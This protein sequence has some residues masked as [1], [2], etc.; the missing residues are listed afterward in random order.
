MFCN[1]CRKL[2][3]EGDDCPTCGKPIAA[4]LPPPTDFDK[5]GDLHEK[6]RALRNGSL[7]PGQFCLYLEEERAKV[8]QARQKLA[9]VEESHLEEAIQSWEQA[10]NYAEQW[11]QSGNDLML[12]SSL[13][14][15]T[16]T[17]ELLKVAVLADWEKT[18]DWIKAEQAV[19]RL[20]NECPPARES[21]ETGFYPNLH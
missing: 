2:V 8:S 17:D 4:L 12:Q 5:K 6:T 15:A 20:S 7:T 19:L 10:L 11:V 1:Q 14:L 16:Q 21:D 3:L 13:A 9:E 18:R